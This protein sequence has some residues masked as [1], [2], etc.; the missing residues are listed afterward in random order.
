MSSQLCRDCD[1]YCVYCQI[2]R[3]D[4]DYHDFNDSCKDFAPEDGETEGESEVDK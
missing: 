2:C 4:K 1:N 3:V